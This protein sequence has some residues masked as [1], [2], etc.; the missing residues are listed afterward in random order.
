MTCRY[1]FQQHGELLR[2]RRLLRLRLLRRLPDGGE[3]HRHRFPRWYLLCD[4]RWY[5]HAWPVQRR[6][7]PDEWD[8]RRVYSEQWAVRGDCW[9]G[10]AGHMVGI[11]IWG[12]RGVGV[13]KSL[14]IFLAV[15]SRVGEPAF[16]FSSRFGKMR[17]LS[18]FLWRRPKSAIV[19]GKTH[20][21][22]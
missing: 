5:L 4:S 16:L 10:N 11:L 19:V 20:M 1:C 18:S 13:G 2:T 22:E 14:G 15:A 9:W 17:L 3:L 21:G 12:V 6:L 8:W 7:F